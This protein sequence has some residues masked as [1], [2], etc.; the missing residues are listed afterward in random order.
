MI[1]K[2]ARRPVL[3]DVAVHQPALAVFYPAVGVAQ[4]QRAGAQRFHLGPDERDARLKVLE[5]L[6]VPPR[7]S[8]DGD[9]IVAR[10]WRLHDRACEACAAAGG[11]QRQHKHGRGQHGR[12]T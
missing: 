2:R 1:E 7:Q 9:L 8:V 3:R 5:D 11:Q 10:R 4:L 6:I 12:V